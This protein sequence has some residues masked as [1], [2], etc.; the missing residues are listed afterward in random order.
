MSSTNIVGHWAYDWIVTTEQNKNANAIFILVIK[1]FE[2][3]KECVKNV[4]NLF[5][6]FKQVHRI[7]AP[8]EVNSLD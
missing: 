4:I 8:M 2:C 3:A 1:N 7:V 5:L 6:M